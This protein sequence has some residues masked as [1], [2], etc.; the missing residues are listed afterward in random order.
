MPVVAVFG[1]RHGYNPDKIRSVL[2]K[3]KN[4]FDSDLTIVVGDCIGVDETAYR[5]CKELGIDVKV[6]VVRDNPIGYQPEPD[7]IVTVIG[8]K[9]PLRIKYARRTHQV[10]LYTYHSNGYFIGFNT[11]GKGSQLM[12]SFI[13]ESLS[14]DEL[15]K[16]MVL[17]N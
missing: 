8:G 12:I 1:S 13:K 5:L 2:L 15:K 9:I 4:K 14:A 3:L 11:S 16:R 17:F 10:F 6:F 7:D